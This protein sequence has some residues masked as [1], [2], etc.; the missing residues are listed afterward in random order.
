[1]NKICFDFQQQS[2]T[3]QR[4]KKKK[5]QPNQKNEID[6]RHTTNKKFVWLRSVLLL[7]INVFF[8]FASS[9][10]ATDCQTC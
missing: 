1:M 2:I 3:E 8:Y 10:Y 9:F 7:P 4:K 6:N 5:S